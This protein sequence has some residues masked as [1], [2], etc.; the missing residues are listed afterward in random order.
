MKW[1]L[2]HIVA[3]VVLV[4]TISATAT[5]VQD[6][7][8]NVDNHVTTTPRVLTMS[9]TLAQTPVLNLTLCSTP[10][11]LFAEDCNYPGCNDVPCNTGVDDPFCCSD[12][13][14]IFGSWD[15]YS[16]GQ[17]DHAQFIC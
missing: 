8:E 13:A 15:R 14:W 9:V 7:V 1:T 6:A 4:S 2:R 17:S 12:S 3:C 10:M 16:H 5:H 11:R